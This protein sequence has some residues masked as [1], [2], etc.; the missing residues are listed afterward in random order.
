MASLGTELVN[1][2]LLNWL[3]VLRNPP[4]PSCLF[5]DLYLPRK[6]AQRA[7]PFMCPLVSHTGRPWKSSHRI[8]VSQVLRAERD[9]SLHL[10][11]RGMVSC[12]GK[13]GM[14][15]PAKIV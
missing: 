11:S 9:V 4:E 14:P 3:V 13:I 8:Q 2:H 15:T 6:D 5:L 7:G 1:K 12:W 10:Y